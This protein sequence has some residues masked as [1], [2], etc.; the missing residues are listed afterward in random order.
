MAGSRGSRRWCFTL[1]NYTDEDLACARDR[2]TADSCRYAVVGVEQAPSTGTPHLQ[3][4]MHLKKQ[5]RLAGLHKM[6][7]NRR[8]HF[9][10]ARGSD[11]ENRDYCRK[12][13]RVLLEVGEPSAPHGT[14]TSFVRANQ[15]AK[16][17]AEKGERLIDILESDPELMEA[18]GKHAAHVDRLIDMHRAREAEVAFKA[19]YES[20]DPAT[21]LRPW[22]RELY[23][24][25]RDS[26][27]DP[28]KIVWYVDWRGGVGKSW[29][30]NFFLSRHGSRSAACFS[31]GR[32][33]DVAYAYEYQR[34][35]FFDLT[36]STPDLLPLCH[37][38]EQLKD[39]RIFSSKYNSRVKLFACPHVVV[40]A[41][42]EPPD[43]AFSPDRLDVRRFV[44][45]GDILKGT[46]GS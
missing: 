29:F 10:V 15:I 9:E 12:S 13:E 42:K 3:G 1:N 19:P 18:Y 46:T 38:M 35:V 32:P 44:V 31:D 34:V 25:L 26:A 5:M 7:F 33:A 17:V 45:G 39:G 37:V 40:F 8:G 21:D 43:L 16:R 6:L 4:Y 30:V 23:S 14:K 41:N 27:P 28:R 36:R 11:Q 20:V 24:E 2:L 22:Q